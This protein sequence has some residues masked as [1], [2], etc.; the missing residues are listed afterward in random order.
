MLP[1][2]KAMLMLMLSW[3]KKAKKKTEEHR[4]DPGST[5]NEGDPRS[6][7][8]KRKTKLAS[9][10]RRRTDSGSATNKGDPRSQNDDKAS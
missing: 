7:N 8:G 2:V 1:N 4:T 10:T 9:A 3:L 6:R 5:T